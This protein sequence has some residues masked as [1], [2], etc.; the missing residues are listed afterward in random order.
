MTGFRL[1]IGTDGR[2]SN[3]RVTSSSGSSALDSM[4]CRILTIRAQF[5]PALDS[6][7]NATTDTYSGRIVWRL[8][9][10]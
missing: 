5:A 4:T 3:C 10:D 1:D 8:P 9:A 6:N 7:G 2:V